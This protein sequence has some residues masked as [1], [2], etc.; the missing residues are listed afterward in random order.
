MIT[1]HSFKLSLK[2]FMSLDDND[3]TAAFPYMHGE[4][5][6]DASTSNST[7]GLAPK[8]NAPITAATDESG[9]ST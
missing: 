5:I 3:M 4:R 1:T 7:N 9:I 8:K 6:P 2:V